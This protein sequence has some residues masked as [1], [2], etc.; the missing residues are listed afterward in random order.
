MNASPP[1]KLPVWDHRTL[2]GSARSAAQA[3]R[4]VRSRLQS[5]PRG[6]VV[7]AWSRDTSIIDLPAG[8]VFSVH[9]AT[10]HAAARR[11]P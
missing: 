10:N 4:L 8:W 6:W 5:I 1:P 11:S 3:E 2:L 9:P 7:S